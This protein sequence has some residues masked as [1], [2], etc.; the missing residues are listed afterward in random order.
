VNVCLADC[1]SA[2]KDAFEI[3]TEL[4]A[5]FAVDNDVNTH[6]CTLSTEAFPW[7]VVDLGAELAVGSIQITLPN[8]NGFNRNYLAL[9][10][11]LIH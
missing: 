7:W 11:L 2:N 5:S 6:S 8:V 4:A 1:L 3:T 9:L 10:A